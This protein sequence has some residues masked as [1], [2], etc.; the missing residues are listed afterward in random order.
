MTI[1]QSISPP[2]RNPVLIFLLL[3][4]TFLIGDLFLEWQS[5]RDATLFPVQPTPLD[6][7]RFGCAVIVEI[8]VPSFS[9]GSS[10]ISPSTSASSRC[11][12]AVHENG[13]QMKT[14]STFLTFQCS[15]FLIAT[16]HS[17]I[18][19]VNVGRSVHATSVHGYC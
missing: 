1:N 15:M 8:E 6:R 11:R 19:L 14:D 16:D 2:V 13:L 18:P 4:A 5:I 3:V 9:C 7:G 12:Y 10:S 17:K